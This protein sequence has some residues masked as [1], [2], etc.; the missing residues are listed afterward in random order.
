MYFSFREFENSCDLD[1]SASCVFVT[2][3]E[4]ATTSN[5][6]LIRIF[7]L[8][9]PT[10]NFEYRIYS[11]IHAN[12][13]RCVYMYDCTCL[14]YGTARK[15][16]SNKW[17]IISNSHCQISLQALQ[18]NRMARTTKK[19]KI[20]LISPSNY[21][22]RINDLFGGICWMRNAWKYKLNQCNQ[23][24]IICIDIWQWTN[25]SAMRAQHKNVARI[26]FRRRR[27]API[28]M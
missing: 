19:K 6:L 24:K 12:G 5:H 23:P 13:K 9:K 15:M 11:H 10:S 8:F 16:A 4:C 14:L 2:C 27:H 25:W 17:R 3:S 21:L 22:L 18:R 1:R 28:E 7:G 20:K 26:S